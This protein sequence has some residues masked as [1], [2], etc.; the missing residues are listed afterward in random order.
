MDGHEP[1]PL[2][3]CGG[4]GSGGSD[5]V[6]RGSCADGVSEGCVVGVLGARVGVGTDVAACA[7]RGVERVGEGDGRGELGAVGRLVGVRV[8]RGVVGLAVG[9]AVG[10]GFG[11]G[12]RVGVG[13]GL[14]AGGG[15]W[16]GGAVGGVG[17]TTVGAAGGGLLGVHD[18]LG[19][20]RGF[21]VGR[22]LC[23]GVG[24]G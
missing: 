19:V 15:D 22:R 24:L 13:V 20:G 23:V 4:T 21:S 12:V 5:G 10:V 16:I 2:G 8:G 17:C 3:G 18:V 9:V 7:G 1:G 14:C 6:D 11:V